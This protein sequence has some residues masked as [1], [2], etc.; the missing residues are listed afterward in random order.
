MTAPGS[1]DTLHSL[2]L[3]HLRL[4]L[5][6]INRVLRA[7]VGRQGQLAARLLRPDITPLCVTDDQVGILLDDMDAV[8]AGDRFDGTPVEST[9]GEAREQDAMH[10]AAESLGGRL[11]F[12]Q[13]VD[14]LSLSPFEQEA[15]LLCTAAEIDRAYERIYAYI[16]D[17][18]N[19]R[20]P[21]IELLSTLTATSLEERAARRAA[22]SRYGKLRRCGVLRAHGDAADS[23]RQELRL[24][25][26]VFEVLT[27]L[28]PIAP[29]RDPEEVPLAEPDSIPPLADTAAIAC[30]AQGM[31]SGWI[32]VVGVWGSRHSDCDEVVRFIASRLARQLRRFQPAKAEPAQV[33]Q[34]C[35][36]AVE[37]AAA[38]GATLWIRLDTSDDG[39]LERQ[40]AALAEVLAEAPVPTVLSGTRPWRPTEL[41]STKSYVE[42]ELRSPNLTERERMWH[43]ALPEVDA[44][45][46]RELAARYRMSSEDIRAAASLGR[47]NAR[48]AGNGHADLLRD[49]LD[50]ACS[51]VSCKSTLRF[52]TFVRPRRGSADLVL[53]PSL[54]E[55]VME[56]AQF[57]RAS[58]QV[59]DAWGF[60][61]HESGSA[62]M[63]ALFTG[64]SGTGKTLAAEVIAAQLRMPLLKVDL[65]QVVS[66][67]V[68]ET[69]KH[70]ES[71]FREAEEAQAVLFFDEAD[72]LFGKRGEVRHGVDRYANL[73]VSYLLQ[74]LEDCGGLIILASN[75]NEN[76]DVAFTRRFQVVLH[77]PRPERAERARIWR[78]AFPSETPIDRSMD[79][80]ALSKLDLTGAGIVGAARAAAL[81]AAK[82]GAVEVGESH[83]IRAIARQFRR[84]A[85]LLTPAD[86]GQYAKLLRE[87]P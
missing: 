37:A 56:V 50:L 3:S 42:I 55:Q 63:R 70:L 33:L 68:G 45:Q 80:D 27:G 82:D 12:E 44:D 39:S 64:D 71:A 87:P 67:W 62:G 13:L 7:A 83:V 29:F 21:C 59:S 19:R 86:L 69:E 8:L 34:R 52:A 48:L 17:D 60:K 51:T 84:E 74:K 28:T 75:L 18:L 2:A 26:G 25:P 54:H 4:R 72:A 57:F 22:I 47:L 58:A 20:L 24:G 78:M 79:F 11:P 40:H 41:L 6:P 32:T 65:S 36:E 77:F 53:P 46:A 14:S 38:L 85:R 61:R 43:A 15:V 66:K 49:H 9:G 76:I 5:R 10:A 35:R 73:E 30:L 23:L 1:L 31:R 16:L 81:L